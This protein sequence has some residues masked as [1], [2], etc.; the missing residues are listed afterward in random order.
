M[1]SNEGSLPKRLAQ[2]LRAIRRRAIGLTLLEGI[3]LTAAAF[4]AAMLAA[5]M[6]D[7]A[8]GWFDTR[9]RYTFTILVLV[10]AAGAFIF[11]CVR[12]LARRRTIV[13]TARDVDQT[14]PQ[15][16]ERWSTVTELSQSH[17]SPEVRGSEAM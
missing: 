6:L 15:L 2:K 12:P 5:M 1:T 14:L 10:A 8:L 9:V 17:D 16:E 3:V 7:W 4:L 13:A 11:W